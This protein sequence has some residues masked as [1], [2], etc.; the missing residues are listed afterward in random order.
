VNPEDKKRDARENEEKEA[1]CCKKFLLE[2]GYKGI[3]LNGKGKNTTHCYVRLTVA[4]QRVNK[5]NS[6][7]KYC[8]LMGY[9]WLFYK[10]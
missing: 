9:I 6:E 10:E 4:P 8:C 3:L 1:D 7:R 2:T 5:K